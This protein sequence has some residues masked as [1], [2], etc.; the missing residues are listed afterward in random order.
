MRERILAPYYI[1]TNLLNWTLLTELVKPILELNEKHIHLVL[2]VNALL[3]RFRQTDFKDEMQHEISNPGELAGLLIKTISY[4]RSFFHMHGVTTRISLV[5]SN[6]QEKA[7]DCDWYNQGP[8]GIEAWDSYVAAAVGLVKTITLSL[9]EVVL[10]QTDGGMITD[11]VFALIESEPQSPVVVVSNSI[12]LQQVCYQPYNYV[13]DTYKGLLFHYYNSPAN[14]HLK[15]SKHKAT[16]GH[17]FPALLAIVGDK[18][19]DIPKAIERIGFTSLMNRIVKALEI[20]GEKLDI[21]DTSIYSDAGTLF[22]LVVDNATTSV[23]VREG[24]NPAHT[25]WVVGPAG[26]LAR[27][28]FRILSLAEQVS[29]HVPN[30]ALVERVN[31][32]LPRGEQIDVDSLFKGVYRD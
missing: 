3:R 13:I 27:N 17:L 22:K 12:L 24:V 6:L 25:Q 29:T 11:L 7:P 15:K 9:P 26:A 28:Q 20:K 1:K 16:L 31:G 18:R 23:P 19:T 30:Y 5:H 10:Y 32:L 8:S 4:Y 21:L 2:D 14:Y